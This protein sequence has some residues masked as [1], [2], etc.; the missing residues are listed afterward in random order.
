MNKKRILMIGIAGISYF[1]E[2][3]DFPREGET[4]SSIN[5]FSE[6][7]GKGL[8]Q[9]IMASK[10]G[11]NVSYIY[12][13][14]NDKTSLD[15]ANFM[16][17]L[18]IKVYP[19]KKEGNSTT[20]SIIVNN[21]GENKVIVF[22][23]KK[24]SLNT[25]DLVKL[26]KI[27][28][29]QDALLLTNEI[30]F[31]TIES[32]VNLANSYNIPI[33]YNPAP[34]KDEY[35]TLYEKISFLTPNEGEFRTIYEIPDSIT[36]E[37]LGPYFCKYRYSTPIIIVTLSSKGALLISNGKY[38]YYSVDKVQSMDTTGAGD[39]FNATFAHFFLNTMNVEKAIIMA[40][41]YSKESVKYKGVL[42]SINNITKN[43]K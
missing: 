18:D 15:I 4:I 22:Q 13:I 29:K 35:Q 19:I 43:I 2:V 6:V 40:I 3:R 38:Q 11:S 23:D 28:V 24:I 12:S 26:S 14:G 32:I 7:G 39:I 36:T 33:I 41:R 5:Y 20:A 37:N 16:K 34:A 21:K 42:N 27:I 10:L 1:F 8:N 25:Q 30:D 31:F 17:K 9:A